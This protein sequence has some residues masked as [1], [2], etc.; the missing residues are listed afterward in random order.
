MII[1]FQQT[2]YDKFGLTP[3]IKISIQLNPIKKKKG[4]RGVTNVSQTHCHAF[5]MSANDI[6]WSFYLDRTV[7]PN[8]LDFLMP[9]VVP[10]IPKSNDS[11]QNQDINHIRGHVR[12]CLIRV[13]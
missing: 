6:N 13:T 10:K 11:R 8:H 1:S 12:A 4:G 9:G 2:E 5:E 3:Q 7:H